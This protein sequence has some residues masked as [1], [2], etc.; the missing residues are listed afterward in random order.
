V[1]HPNPAQPAATV[2]EIKAI[3]EAAFIYG[4]R[5]VMNDAT[6]QQRP[7]APTSQLSGQRHIRCWKKLLRYRSGSEAC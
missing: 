1:V 6:K 7:L 2:A 4:L 5:I 3:D